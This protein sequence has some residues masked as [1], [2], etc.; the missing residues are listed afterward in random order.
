MSHLLLIRHS[1]TAP[2]AE[3]AAKTWRLTREGRRRCRSLADA[4][5]G[6]Q[7]ERLVTSLELKASLTGQLAAEHL[8]LPWQTAPNLHEQERD[9]VPFFPSQADFEAAVAQLFRKPSQLVF[10]RETAN[11]ARDRFVQ[12]VE[13]VI[14]AAGD[15]TSDIAIVSH[16]TVISLFVALH[17]QLDVVS[18]WRNLGMPAI[19]VL[20]LPSF[21]LEKVIDIA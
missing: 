2:E 3:K 20:R 5:T 7:L 8:N 21:T 11:Q 13:Q 19:V 17:N 12:A 6:Y 1:Q 16:G 10:G 18:F 15:E 9:Q 4:L 14:V